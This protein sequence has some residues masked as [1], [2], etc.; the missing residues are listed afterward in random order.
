ML[1]LE[2]CSLCPRMCGINR[3]TQHGFCA[4]PAAPKL[5]RAALHFW[6]EPCISG[7]NGSGTVFF[8]HCNLKCVFCQNEKI[9]AGGF[10]KEITVKRLGEIFLDLQNQGAHNINLVSPT[11]YVPFIIK[12]L[13]AVKP[14]LKIPVAYN[15][16]GYENAECIDALKGYVDIFIPDLKYYSS[17]LSQKYSCAPD[18][19]AVAANA[20][21]QMAD[22]AGKPRLNKDNIMQSGVIVRHLCLPGHINDSL[23]LLEKMRQLFKPDEIILSLMSQYTPCSKACEYK[24]LNRRISSYEYN[25]AVD[26]AVAL[27]FTNGFMQEKSSAK[28]EYTPPFDLSGV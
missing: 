8:S 22:N 3:Y 13:D 15:C 21:R 17:D 19:F 16:G 24:N 28:E 11:P 26:K 25:K 2:H 4:A 27:G 5:A 7:Q 18:Y 10:G 6:E 12:A 14:R 1:S 9:S 20:I 23:A